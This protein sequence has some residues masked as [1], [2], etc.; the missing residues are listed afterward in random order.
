MFLRNVGIRPQLLNVTKYQN[1][2][3]Q[4]PY[5]TKPI[6]ESTDFYP[7]D[8]GSMFLRNVGI[9]PQLRGDTKYETFSS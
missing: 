9:H 3:L 6:L 5:I 2:S 7:E 1:I 4:L 8:G